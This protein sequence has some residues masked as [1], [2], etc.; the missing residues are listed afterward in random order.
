MLIVSTGTSQRS[1]RRTNV[2]RN[3]EKKRP[4][5]RNDERRT[6]RKTKSLKKTK[7]SRDTKARTNHPNVA[8]QNLV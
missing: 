2:I 7:T 1:P 8:K 6:G 4:K 5:M 3:V